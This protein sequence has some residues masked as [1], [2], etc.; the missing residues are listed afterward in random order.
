MQLPCEL[1][2]RGS[3]NICVSTS[4]ISNS[5]HLRSVGIKRCY[6][7]ESSSRGDDSSAEAIKNSYSNQI[8]SGFL[9]KKRFM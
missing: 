4:F 6:Y 5:G 2:L 9:I 1:V 3:A 7:P 8:F